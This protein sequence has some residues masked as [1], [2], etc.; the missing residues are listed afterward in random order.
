MYFC[1]HREWRKIK[2]QTVTMSHQ[3]KLNCPICNF[4]R[5]TNLSRHLTTVHAISGKERKTLLLRACFSVSSMQPDQPQPSVPEADST[6]T[7]FGNSLPK[8]S[9]LPQQKK[10]PNPTPDQTEDDLI[11]CPY[12]NCISLYYYIYI[13]LYY[14]IQERNAELSL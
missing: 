11:S 3:L 12:D 6:P 2:I 1:N 13:I 5:L 14:F 4:S 8:T 9:P 7:Q 10:L